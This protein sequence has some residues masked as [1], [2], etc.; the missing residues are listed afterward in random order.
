MSSQ[1][2]PPTGA[3]QSRFDPP[4]VMAPT[5]LDFWRSDVRRPPDKRAPRWIGWV[6]FAL[7]L[8]AMLTLFTGAVTEI[9]LLVDISLGLSLT[10]G[11]L[12]LVAVISGVGRAA[13]FLG[14]LFAL[15][16][17]VFV[18]GWLGQLFT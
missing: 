3:P 18:I 15:A 8:L 1:P 4:R 14:L 17:N 5:I 13:G 6:A 9:G 11:F 16:G 10:A 2:P 12:G 7:G